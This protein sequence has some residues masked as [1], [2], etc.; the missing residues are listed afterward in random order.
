MSRIS[1]SATR[2][3]SR[4]AISYELSAIGLGPMAFPQTFNFILS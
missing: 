3:R 1:L 4:S 2:T